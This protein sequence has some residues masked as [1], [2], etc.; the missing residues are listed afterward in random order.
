MTQKPPSRAELE[1]LTYIAENGPCPVRPVADYFAESKNYVRPTVLKMM[2]RLREKGHL[3]R[4]RIDKVFVYQSVAS[5]DEI[6]NMLV[7][8]FVSGA[9]DGSVS[10]VVAYLAGSE[11]LSAE[12][13]EQ[14]R[15]LIDKL[16]QEGKA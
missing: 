11:A 3:T 15:A 8:E 9:L 2:E 4:R 1:I 16:E 12:D 13:I 14:L 5:A 7:E 10:P 6:A